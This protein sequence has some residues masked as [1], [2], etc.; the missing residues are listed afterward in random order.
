MLT[1]TRVKHESFTYL[2]HQN[3][4][5]TRSASYTSCAS[6]T[7]QGYTTYT[8]VALRDKDTIEGS[9]VHIPSTLPLMDPADV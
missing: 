3:R 6:Y 7:Y 8:K 5:H 9:R 1:G 4:L 2:R